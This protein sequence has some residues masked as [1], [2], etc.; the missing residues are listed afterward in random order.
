[1]AGSGQRATP[2]VHHAVRASRL[3]RSLTRP[4]AWPGR[5]W[6]HPDV[7]GRLL[8]GSGRGPVVGPARV[9]LGLSWQRYKSTPT[10]VGSRAWWASASKPPWRRPVCRCD[11]RR[12]RTARAQR[13]GGARWVTSSP[14]RQRA[15]R[16]EEDGRPMVERQMRPRGGSRGN[17]SVV[18]ESCTRTACRSRWQGSPWIRG[19]GG[20]RPRRQ[21]IGPT[22]THAHPARAIKSLRQ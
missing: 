21:A 11:L 22:G 1:M 8:P 20:G 5:R 17:D 4:G 3:R 10:A 14:W 19:C 6:Q 9:R 7:R 18:A 12:G 13:I 15:F 16:A 2:L